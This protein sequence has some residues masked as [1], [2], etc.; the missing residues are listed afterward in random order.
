[1]KAEYLR[2]ELDSCNLRTRAQHGRPAAGPE[3]QERGQHRPHRPELQV[4]VLARLT[5][6]VKGAAADGCGAFLRRARQPGRVAS[7]RAASP[8][9]Q[10]DLSLDR[11]DT[12]S[13]RSARARRERLRPVRLLHPAARAE[14]DRSGHRGAPILLCEAEEGDRPKAG[15][16]GE[17]GATEAFGRKPYDAAAEA[18]PPL[19]AP[20]PSWN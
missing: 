18:R 15:G 14:E 17:P 8:D 5:P 6:V 4:L 9:G 11:Y 20:T 12:V 7:I 2:Y 19:G 1:M 16:G 13:G 10:A 3:G